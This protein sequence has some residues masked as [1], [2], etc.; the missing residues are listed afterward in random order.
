L[1]PLVLHNPTARDLW[2]GL[3]LAWV[4]SELALHGRRSARQ[5]LFSDW[6]YPVVLVAVG[7][8][9]VL[10]RRLAHLGVLGG[11]WTA[12]AAGA[13]VVVVG[14]AFRLWAIVVLGR[15]FTTR[16]A[17]QPGHRVV[18]SGP[19]RVLRHPSYTGM[20]VALLGLGVMFDS[21]PSI[22]TLA[23]LP[24]AGLL[25][26]IHVEERMLEDAL[27]DEYRRYEAETRRLVPGVW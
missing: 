3:V 16:V 26:R 21:W 27:G 17:I 4:G 15:L 14:V 20:L 19:Y 22:L 25:V 2:I 6:T 23:I 13:A 10:A 24:L 7:G 18:R 1:D 8:G 12:V 5:S 11:G 9:I